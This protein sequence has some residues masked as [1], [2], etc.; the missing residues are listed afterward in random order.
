MAIAT[1]TA[2]ALGG[3]AISAG[4]AG[5]SF[6]QAAAAKRKGALAASAAAKAMADARRKLDI[7]YEAARSIQ[8]EPYELQREAM[9]SAG[10]QA[11]QAGVE[12]ERGVAATAGRIAAQQSEAQGQIR[13][14]MGQ[15]LTQLEKDTIAEQS[16]LRDMGVGL[17]LETVKGA[18]MAE[19]QAEEQRNAA[20]QQGVSMAAE[21]IKQGIS[22]IPLYGR[23]ASAAQFQKLQGAYDKA[24]ASGQKMKPEFYDAS[25]KPLS[26]QQAV[27]K[28]SNVGID[29]SGVGQ[30]NA[31]AFDQF[32]MGQG[33]KALR[34]LNRFD[35]MLPKGG[36]QAPA[37]PAT[38]AGVATQG[39]GAKDLGFNPL[40]P[41]DIFGY[42]Y[43]QMNPSFIR[44]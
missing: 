9:I 19:A 29:V 34:G 11:T 27:G 41:Y 38:P 13:A 8:K 16:R 31:N 30:L 32:M 23:D 26:F 14:E 18:Q 17:D 4:A 21:G 28:M 36:A 3:M 42:Q 24:V 25:G 5:M 39:K 40:N 43:Q 6:G 2:L 35:F 1:S 33:A 20:I 15:E 22:Q 12:S 44:R 10:A 37:T 7:N